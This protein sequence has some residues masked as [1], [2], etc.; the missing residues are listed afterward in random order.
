VKIS[1][2]IVFEVLAKAFSN[3]GIVDAANHLID[4]LDQSNE[5][6]YLLMKDL[7]DDYEY[8]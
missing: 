5:G 2:K 1:G 7:L 6:C 3:S 4:L 8:I